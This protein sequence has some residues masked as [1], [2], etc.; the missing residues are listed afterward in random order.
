MERRVPIIDKVIAE[1]HHR[2]RASRAN[3]Q[4]F[5]K[6]V[7]TPAALRHAELE[8]VEAERRRLDAAHEQ[9]DGLDN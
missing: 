9:Q 4:A 6:F 2:D 3:R 5:Q 1:M 7:E 8:R